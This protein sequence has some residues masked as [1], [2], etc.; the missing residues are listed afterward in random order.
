M[1]E[2]AAVV[3]EQLRA[4]RFADG[5]AE[6]A[7]IDPRRI[8]K[9]VHHQRWSQDCRGGHDGAGLGAQLAEA[10][11]HDVFETSARAVGALRECPSVGGGLEVAACEGVGQEVLHQEWKSLGE[12]EM[13]GET[14]RR[15]LGAEHCA[16]HGAD[17]G[18]RE[19][20]QREHRGASATGSSDEVPTRALR[21]GGRNDE[22]RLR[23][24][25]GQE[26]AEHRNGV[27]VGC[28][29][30][31]D[32]EHA[33]WSDRAEG[34]Q[35][36]VAEEHGCRL[37]RERLVLDRYEMRQ[38][39]GDVADPTGEISGEETGASHQRFLDRR[40]RCGR[41][42]VGCAPDEHRDAPVSAAVPQPLDEAALSHARFAD[43]HDP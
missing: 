43:D 31:L 16:D 14:R 34:A 36:G 27:G 11:L 35:H 21:T 29:D 10:P 41:P 23:R 26:M 1:A 32:D 3:G 6:S 38:Q 13:I 5:G 8:R 18:I 4:R 37:G 30:V 33:A 20:I 22:H 12:L 40:K 24:C 25:V 19:A 42:S 28:V 9:H 17:L 7:R 39:R 2:P 15:V